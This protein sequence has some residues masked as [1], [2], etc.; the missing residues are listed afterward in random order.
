M[1]VALDQ[2][3]H[4]H[5]VEQLNTL[6]QRWVGRLVA[7]CPNERIDP[8]VTGEPGTA[9]Q[10]F[11]EIDPP[12]LHRLQPLDDKGEGAVADLE[13]VVVVNSDVA[14]G[15]GHQQAV[16]LRHNIGGDPHIVD[17]GGDQTCPVDATA[18]SLVEF[19][20]DQIDDP[21][22]WALADRRLDHLRLVATRDVLGDLL[23]HQLE[24]LADLLVVE[25]VRAILAEH[26]L[27][28]VG[29][30]F[31]RAA[32]GL[33]QILPHHQAREGREE[34]AIQR[35]GN[36]RRFCRRDACHRTDLLLP[37]T[38]LFVHVCVRY[39]TSCALRAS[40][41]VMTTHRVRCGGCCCPRQSR[42]R[43]RCRAPGC[44]AVCRCPRSRPVSSGG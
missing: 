11:L 9:G 42:L 39:C 3:H 16:V 44:A 14:P 24:S 30:R 36:K 35:V 4:P 1:I 37:A 5:Q 7:H 25:E 41:V 18:Q 6:G 33:R 31:A 43:S 2:R 26:E 23:L 22:R 32:D 13:G 8:L 21:A 10:V 29:G 15:A 40:S 12:D 17:V 38:P 28:D 27:D 19:D 20:L 34:L